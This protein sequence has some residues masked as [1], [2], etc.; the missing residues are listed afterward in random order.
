MKYV[1]TYDDIIIN[2]SSAMTVY[3]LIVRQL[4]YEKYKNI[5]HAIHNLN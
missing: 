4:F 3:V 1:C 5:L 2:K